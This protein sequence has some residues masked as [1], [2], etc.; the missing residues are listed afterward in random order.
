MPRDLS[1][2]GF[3]DIEQAGWRSHDLTTARIP[4]D[5]LVQSVVDG[6]LQQI[7]QPEQALAD[8]LID[9]PIMLRGTT[10]PPGGLQSAGGGGG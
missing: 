4:V 3:S 9:C 7:E 8:V 5:A 10:L 6:M 2:V 1:I